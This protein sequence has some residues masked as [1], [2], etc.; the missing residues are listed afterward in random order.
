MRFDCFE[1]RKLSDS[2]LGSMPDKSIDASFMGAFNQ[3]ED[4]A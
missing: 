2:K 4:L 3:R 1:V